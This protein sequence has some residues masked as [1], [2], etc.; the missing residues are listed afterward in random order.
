MGKKVIVGAT[1]IH[2]YGKEVIKTIVTKAGATVFDLG[3]YVTPDEL[4]ETI[5]ET[6]AK[7]IFISTYN[8]IALT[9]ATEVVEK[10]KESGLD[11]SL[12]IGG[13]LNENMDGGSLAEDVTDQIKALGVNADNNMD[14]TVDIIEG[15]YAKS[16]GKILAS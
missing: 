7:A 6:E 9:Y 16:E 2:D 4:I 12:V 10:I 11:A 3:S 5:I 14:L 13:Q 8:G 1:D 15:I